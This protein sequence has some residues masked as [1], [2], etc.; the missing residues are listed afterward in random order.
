[1]DLAVLKKKISSYKTTSGRLTKVSDELAMEILQAW[2]QWTGP[3]LRFYAEI[4]VSQNKMTKVIAKGK[5]LKR[6]G[7]FVEHFK[8]IEV[9]A[10][11]AAVPPG[12]HCGIELVWKDN[13]IRF[14]DASLL[15]DFLK[16]AA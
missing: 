11:P 1:M 2:E 14:G 3:A 10:P 12:A 5:E 6:D 7:R 4:G 8:E 16:K 13:V 9:E 15:L